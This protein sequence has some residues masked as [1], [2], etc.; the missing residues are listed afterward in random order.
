RNDR[1]SGRFNR[2][3]F[4]II[5]R[6]SP[7]TSSTVSVK[8]AGANGSRGITAYGAT[9][10]CSNAA[11][12]SSAW[13][14]RGYHFSNSFNRSPFMWREFKVFFKR[15]NVMDLGGGVII[16]GAVGKIVSSVGD[17]LVSPGLG[18]ITGGLDFCAMGLS[19]GTKKGGGK[20]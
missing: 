16:G 7:C 3:Y 19:V 20:T 6:A 5:M 13:I 12:A 14:E 10:S 4:P 8:W 17:D 1:A 15:G 11:V 2:P 9:R 18:K